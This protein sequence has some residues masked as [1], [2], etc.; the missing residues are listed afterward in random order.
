MLEEEGKKIVDVSRKR[1]FGLALSYHYLTQVQ[2]IL[3]SVIV[4][5]GATKLMEKALRIMKDM[6]AKQDIQDKYVAAITAS[7]PSL[8]I[9]ILGSN[10]LA[11]LSAMS[12][13]TNMS[14]V[15]TFLVEV[16]IKTILPSKAKV[17]VAS[18]QQLSPFLRLLTHDEMA[19]ILMPVM[20]KALLRSPEAEAALSTVIIVTLVLAQ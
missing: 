10:L 16:L 19:S 13:D 7:D 6:W 12:A 8:N 5:S 20:N 17:S 9:C 14:K 2:S 4:S 1:L 3:V 18:V 11:S 15:K